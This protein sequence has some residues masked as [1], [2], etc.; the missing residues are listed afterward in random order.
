MK[1]ALFERIQINPVERYESIQELYDS[2]FHEIECIVDKQS[3][4]S[5][6]IRIDVPNNPYDSYKLSSLSSQ[7]ERDIMEYEPRLINPKVSAGKFDDKNFVVVMW[8]SGDVKF[9]NSVFSL[10]FSSNKRMI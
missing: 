2:I 6:N 4:S 10:K 3:I 5:S 8:I 1:P 9:E 7:I